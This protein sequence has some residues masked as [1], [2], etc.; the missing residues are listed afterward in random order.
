MTIQRASEEP[1]RLKAARTHARS[2]RVTA[3]AGCAGERCGSASSVV[4]GLYVSSILISLLA[5]LTLVT[6][7]FAPEASS[8]TSRERLYELEVSGPSSSGPRALDRGLPATPMPSRSSTVLR[9]RAATMNST[10]SD[11]TLSGSKPPH[12]GALVWSTA[13]EAVR[14]EPYV[15]GLPIPV[16]HLPEC[17]QPTWLR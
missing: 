14:R 7:R 1:S 6:L 9:E 8:R 11:P 13:A 4:S 3:R 16:S 10:D 15:F 2:D 17:V 5:A 12:R